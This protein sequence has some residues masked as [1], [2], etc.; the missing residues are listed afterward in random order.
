MLSDPTATD[1]TI[2]DERDYYFSQE[3][4]IS[5]STDTKNP[6]LPR[7]AD[8]YCTEETAVFVPNLVFRI[9]A[10]SNTIQTVDL[11]FDNKHIK[12]KFNKLGEMLEQNRKIFM[13]HFHVNHL[14]DKDISR[15]CKGLRENR[16][17]QYLIMESHREDKITRESGTEVLRM[18]LSSPHFSLELM[19]IPRG[20][21]PD[22]EIQEINNVCRNN[23]RIKK[24]SQNPELPREPD[25][26]SLFDHLRCYDMT[27]EELDHY[28][29]QLLRSKR[30]QQI[31][32]VFV[33][34]TP[35]DGSFL[36]KYFGANGIGRNLVSAAFIDCG[37]DLHFF[38]EQEQ[39]GNLP[40]FSKLNVSGT[41]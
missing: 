31:S 35:I 33:Y 34:N 29:F 20:S 6:N 9:L 25:N 5:V 14:T 38:F 2:F 40:V 41:H 12:Y 36:A 8:I 16:T 37:V 3:F 39:A 32:S 11:T 24:R 28:L 22:S 13:M 1:F 23:K 7:V 10:N 18:L 26:C 19:S 15:A 27:T 17:L 30:L 4:R 21:I